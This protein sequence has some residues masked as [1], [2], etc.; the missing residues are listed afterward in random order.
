MGP[1]SG[2]SGADRTQV[3]PMDGPMYI[4]IWVITSERLQDLYN[5]I[6]PQFSMKLSYSRIY[7]EVTTVR[8]NYITVDITD[9]IHDKCS[10]LKHYFKI[11]IL[12]FILITVLLPTPMWE[13]YVFTNTHLLF[14]LLETL[15]K[16]INKCPWIV[17][18]TWICCAFFCGCV[19]DI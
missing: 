8:F 10:K 13:S 14:C 7:L 11:N 5:Q 19:C 9:D 2:P 12:S 15:Q 17:W 4:V 6:N 1:A 3:G 16:L 18:G